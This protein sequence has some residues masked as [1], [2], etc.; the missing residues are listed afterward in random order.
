MK[1]GYKIAAGVALVVGAYL[2]YSYFKPK[3]DKKTTPAPTP[4]PTPGGGT[5]SG[6]CSSTNDSFPL[7]K[8]SKGP[9]V[10]ELQLALLKK[11][12]SALPRFGADCDFGTETQ[13]AL[14]TLYNRTTV[15]TQAQLDDI[16]AGR[17]VEGAPL[18]YTYTGAPKPP[19]GLIGLNL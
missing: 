15:E 12:P 10:K 4:E 2:V 17:Y 19:T 7:K 14:K 8:G 3:K 6:P 5:Q 13:T 18:V 11:N 16:K 1:A 9:K